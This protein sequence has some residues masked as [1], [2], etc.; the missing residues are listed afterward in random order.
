M[1]I[2]DK[3]GAGITTTVEIIVEKNR[4]LAQLNRLSAIIRT[5]SEVINHAYA[6]LGRHY[7][8]ILENTETETD[9]TN[10]CEVIRFS[11]ERRKKAQARYDYIKAFGMP[12]RSMDTADM[13]R[14]ADADGENFSEYYAPEGTEEEENGDITIAV[15]DEEEQN[16]QKL[17]EEEA[18]ADTS[19]KKRSRK[20]SEPADTEAE[21]DLTDL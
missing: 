18:P 15:A 6:A 1:T 10:I 16:K 9:M 8:K 14:P 7:Y 21:D 2:L 11:E 5:E 20:K 19:S 17:S 12:K 3:I 4:Q 13:F